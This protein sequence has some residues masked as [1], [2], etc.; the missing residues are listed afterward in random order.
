[1]AERQNRGGR[2]FQGHN[3]SITFLGT[4]GSWPTAECNVSATA[5]KRGK[6]VILFDC[7]EGTQRQF[8]MSPVSHMQVSKIFLTHHHGDHTFG[9][10]GYL[11]TM[12][13]NERQD[14]LDIYGPPGTLRLM[15]KFLDIAPIRN[16]YLVRVHE[17]EP[18]VPLHFDEGYTI[19]AADGDHSIRNYAYALEEDVRP[20]R[21]DKTGALALGVPEGPAFRRLQLGQSVTTPD[22]KEVTPDMVLGPP[23]KGRKIAISG[24]TRPC[25]RIAE[26]AR[27]ADVLIHEATYVHEE[28]ELAKENHHTTAR[29]AA[30]VAREAQA[31]TLWLH[32]FSPRYKDRSTHLVEARRIFP[33]TFLADDLTSTDV[34]FRE[35]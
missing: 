28:V 7:G 30:E 3:L 17:M 20:G 27:D 19:T 12:A 33:N 24:D 29:E 11:K 32:H 22:G 9:I 16:S 34:P 8:Q 26:L 25:G 14:P 23:R 4:S 31:H 1:M 13:L 35:A 10:P 15:G 18:N 5:L 6:E 21:F 2:A